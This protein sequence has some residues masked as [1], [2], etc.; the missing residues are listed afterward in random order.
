M[1]AKPILGL[2]SDKYKCQKHVFIGVVLLTGL[3]AIGLRY[4]PRLSVESTVKISCENGGHGRGYAVEIPGEGVCVNQELKI[5]GTVSCQVN[6][7][8]CPSRGKNY[9]ARADKCFN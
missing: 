9:C 6:L 3:S 5:N 1:A 2:I 7:Y 4:I 8:Q